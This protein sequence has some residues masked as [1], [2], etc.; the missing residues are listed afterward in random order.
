MSLE[1]K[2]HEC[3]KLPAIGVQ[4]LY[5]MDEVHRKAKTWQLTIRREATEDDLEKNH[6]LEEIGETIWETTIEITHCPFCGEN[7]L[8]KNDVEYKDLGLFA[9]YEH[10]EWNTKKQ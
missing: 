1:W 7:L 5:S 3:E 2:L 10:S 4:I 9:H 8:D 6:I